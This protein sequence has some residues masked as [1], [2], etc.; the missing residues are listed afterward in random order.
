MR[1][2]LRFKFFSIVCCLI[3]FNILLV[4]LLNNSLLEKYYFYTKKKIL[5]ENYKQ[6]NI[7]YKGDP[8]GIASKLEELEHTRGLRVI[9]QDKAFNTK[10]DSIPRR[11][12]Q[13]QSARV[14]SSSDA[15]G[16]FEPLFQSKAQQ[17]LKGGI[18]FENRQDPRL[19]SNFITLF[20]LLNN[21]D[22]ILISTPV[23]AIEE[24]VKINNNFFLL[25]GLIT[26]IIGSILIV[27]ITR[28]FT[29]PILQLNDIAM[30]MST[31]DFSRRYHVNSSD[32]IGQLGESI[33]SL[34]EQLQ[35]SILELKEANEKLKED[36]ERERKID[37]MRKE[38]ISSISHELK[39]PIALIQGYA[40]GLK[41]NV[42]KD[43]ENKNFYCEVITDEALKMNKLVKQLLELAQ[44]ESGELQLDKTDF[45]ISSLVEKVLKKNEM[46]FGD[47]NI[48]LFFRHKED[49]FVN[50]DY[51]K[52]E[53]V[54]MNYISNAVN[55]AD[56]RKIIKVS[57]EQ[58]GEKSR[59]SIY[60]S[61]A[62]IPQDSLDKIWS[63]FY[64]VDKARTRAYG[65][66]GLGLSIVRA[67]QEMHNNSYGVNN[68]EGGVEFW[69][70]VDLASQS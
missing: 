16:P 12:E 32:E 6:I 30:K 19:N 1:Y 25:A 22:Y 33:N 7:L 31:M 49:I 56:A 10:Y 48:N 28:R 11:Q 35:K 66:T 14:R 55:H 57:V 2:S 17:L 69:F 29:K 3:I 62:H 47:N 40:E 60:N 24:S 59:I 44:F 13:R 51:D 63:S 38:F 36:I 26:I 37:E 8:E 34:S 52:I 61:G 58:H 65:G 27:I 42:N 53:Q 21:G 43:E 64:K 5:S 23:A 50:A 4:W 67:I 68:V 9:I 41:L 15:R 20:S 18:I 54:L 70:D 45:N 39:T 46:I